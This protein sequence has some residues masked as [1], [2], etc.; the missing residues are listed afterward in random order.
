LGSK[1]T[2]FEH[3]PIGTE[4]ALCQRYYES[5]ST[6]QGYQ[7]FFCGDVTNGS[8]YYTTVRFA[9]PK[10]KN[11]DIVPTHTAASGFSNASA[12]VQEVDIHAFR[13][14]RSCNSTTAGGFYLDSWTADAEL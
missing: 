4:L 13:A 11:P 1:A 3:R 8:L 10:A 14:T 6:A 5:S 9:T 2:T 12:S 7:I